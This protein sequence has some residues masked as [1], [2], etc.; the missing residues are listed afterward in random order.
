MKPP[1]TP[2]GLQLAST[3]RTV[4]RGFNQALT[5]AGGSLPIWLILSSLKGSDWRTQLELARSVGIEGPT[6]TRHL[7]GM[8]QAGLVKRR[9]HPDDR[10]AFQVELTAAGEAMHTQL[11][12][13][14]IS[15]NTRLRRGI[16]GAEVEALRG[17]LERM[18][19]NVREER[20]GG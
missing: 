1:G 10:R 13:S 4:G 7:D 11:L 18:A 2:I 19:A 17:T 20:G 8:E 16:T 3:A 12:K 9:R 15:F 14:V 6:L 5:E